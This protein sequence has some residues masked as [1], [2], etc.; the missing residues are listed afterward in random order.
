VNAIDEAKQKVNDL[1]QESNRLKDELAS[2]EATAKR[3]RERLGKIEGSPWDRYSGELARAKSELAA[4]ERDEADK[5]L[6]RVVWAEGFE[7]Q[8]GDWVLEKVTPKRICVRKAGSNET[9]LFNHDGMHISR[10]RKLRIDIEKTFPEG[11]K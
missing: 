7:P 8:D 3:A 11:L 9:E 5:T 6:P 2:A 4:A 1:L 10:G